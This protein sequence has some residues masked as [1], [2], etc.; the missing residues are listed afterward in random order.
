MINPEA[1]VKPSS[2][3][4]TFGPSNE[5]REG[6][7]YEAPNPRSQFWDVNSVILPKAAF[8]V[9]QLYLGK[10]NGYPWSPTPGRK[11]PQERDH[12]HRAWLVRMAVGGTV[13]RQVGR[14]VEG[15]GSRKSA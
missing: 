6:D 3:Q 15:R 12:S 11:D 13:P 2:L 7:I 14:A 10:R 5:G 8:P 4:L 1:L 9:K